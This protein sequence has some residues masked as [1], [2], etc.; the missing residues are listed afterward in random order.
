M[1]QEHQNK[2]L[3]EVLE[4]LVNHGSEGMSAVFEKLMNEAM[5]VERSEF[6]KAKPYERTAERVG[7]ANGFKEKS[8]QLRNGVARVE[9]PQVRGLSFYPKS[10]ERGCR[11]ER[12]FKLAIAE[13]Y[14]MGVSTRKVS[15][16]TE[17]LCG[18]EVSSTQVSRVAK[19]LDEELGRFRTRPLGQ[20]AYLMLDARYE[21]VR[22][23][24][25]VI[26]C[27]VLI[28]LGVNEDG[29]GEILGVSVSLSEAEV[30][31]REF[32]ESLQ[33]RGLNGLLL[34][35]S[36]DHS[37]LQAARRAVFPSVP[38]QRCQFHMAQNAQA[39]APSIQMRQE[40]G[41]TMR[42]IFNAPSLE[43]AKEMARKARMKYQKSAPKFA[44]WLDQNIEQS[45]TIYSFPRT[46]WR[47][48]RTTNCLE[49][50]NQEIKRRTKVARLFPSPE[51]CLRL[52][53]AILADINDEWLQEARRFFDMKGFNK[54]RETLYSAN[55]RNTVA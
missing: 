25:M 44:E 12:A 1:T 43:Q 15:E 9:I 34:I 54:W 16:I 48:L 46:H 8:I 28:A 39:Y 33:K 52:V 50:V 23:A 37:G 35:T 22:H 41:H 42:D 49:R 14:V 4:T 53:S 32:L 7:Y 55:Y 10:L 19:M 38:W 2:L 13:M 6:L 29:H 20:F 45:F 3:M 27:G 18:A 5:K 47:R 17:V 40:I 24:G 51:S 11:S 26:D 30:H 31:W 21:K 36:D